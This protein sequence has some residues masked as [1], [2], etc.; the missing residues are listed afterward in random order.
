MKPRDRQVHHNIDRRLDAPAL[1]RR[2]HRLRR[3]QIGV[4]MHEVAAR[5]RRVGRPSVTNANS[6]G[7]AASNACPINPVAPVRRMRMSQM[8]RRLIPGHRR[9]D[10]E[11]RAQ[12][13]LDRVLAL[14]PL[15]RR[16]ADAA[17]IVRIVQDCAQMPIQS[18]SGVA[19]LK[20]GGCVRKNAAAAILSN[21]VTRRRPR[22]IVSSATPPNAAARNWSITAIA[23]PLVDFPYRRTRQRL[24]PDDAILDVLAGDK[25]A[26]QLQLLAL[27]H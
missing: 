3:A 4:D 16:R 6:G 26:A 19:A 5:D 10:R 22:A 12:L 17:Q 1:Q 8:A 15:A 11:L 27:F 7:A 23:G 20:I 24:D 14:H 18:P 13:P 2:L 9:E 21:R 25:R